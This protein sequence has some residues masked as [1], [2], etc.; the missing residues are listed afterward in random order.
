[1]KRFD[2]ALFGSVF[3]DHVLTGLTRLP[4]PGE[5]VF[6]ESYQREVGGGCF[7]TACGMALLGSSP[8]CFALVG[9]ED[10]QWMLDRVRSFGVATDQVRFSDLPTGVTVSASLSA[11]ESAE[12]AFFTYD[13]ANQALIDCL[14]SPELPERLAV[15]RHV[16][17][18]CPI[19]PTKGLQIV[20]KLHQL[21]STASLDVGWHEAWLRNPA[22]WHLLA[23]LDWF[24][25][26]ESEARLMTGQSD[27]ENV[28]RVF[29]SRGARRVV[30]KRGPH[31]ATLWNGVEA[32]RAPGVAVRVVDTTGA[33]DAFNAGFLHA[34]LAGLSET[35][36]LNRGTICGSLSTRQA[37]SLA[38]FPNL[39]EVLE[40]HDNITKR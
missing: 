8:T 21:G 38:A 40:Y 15:A 28:L 36:C 22:S 5:E 32:L 4:G 30:V 37:G 6:A 33:G 3:V 13:G 29:A 23:E 1:M 19:S 25:P 24:L 10:S 18:A 12:R 2:I 20:R 39:N 7:N 16:H 34:F 26:N 14:E 35:I 11:S 9:R 17:F 31:G 27:M